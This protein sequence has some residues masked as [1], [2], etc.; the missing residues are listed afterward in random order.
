MAELEKTAGTDLAIFYNKI[1]FFL[2]NT[3]AY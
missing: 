1:H 3:L 2:E